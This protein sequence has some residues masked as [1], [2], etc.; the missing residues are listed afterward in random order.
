M[1]VNRTGEPAAAPAGASIGANGSRL[2]PTVNRRNPMM[3]GSGSMSWQGKA[4]AFIT[5]VISSTADQRHARR[6]PGQI[7]DQPAEHCQL[8]DE[9]V[10][11]W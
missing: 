6:R 11:A 1:T 9:S 4:Q 2:P 10:I 5:M 8:A 3:P 7:E